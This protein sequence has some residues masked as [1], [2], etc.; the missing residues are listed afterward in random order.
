M[1]N[2]LQLFPQYW[3]CPDRPLPLL[4]IGLGSAL[5]ALRLHS[6]LLKVLHRSAY[7]P[8][9]L[10]V[11][12]LAIFFSPTRSSAL[13]PEA[14]ETGSLWASSPDVAL[15]LFP[16]YWPYPERP[17]P[18]LLIG[19]GSALEALRLHSLLLKVLHR[20]AYCPSALPVPPLAIFFSPTRSSALVPEAKETGS[21][22]ASSPDVA[23][24][25]FPHYWPYPERPLPL[26]L[27]GLGSALEAL[28][29]HSLLLKVLHR[30]AYC[31]SA[32]PVPPLAIF[33]SPTRS[34]ALVP[35]AKETGSLWASSPDVA[36]QLF[37]HYWPYPE[38]PLPL[39]LTGL[40]SALEALRLHSLLLKVL[41][42]SAYCPSALPVPHLAIF[43]SPTRSSALV[44]EAKE[45]DSLWASSPDVA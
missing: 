40:G 24:Q 34:S 13:V 19:L 28:R 15:Q 5:E 6:L 8:S 20:S 37:P 11:P 3:P 27:I 39:L 36:L 38:R 10:P 16:H 35:E 29:L 7:C 4:L 41:H 25:L 44:P 26:L 18:L 31:P 33:F 17:L 9:A 22:W 14:K 45:T 42:R 43:F 21:L 32:L 30:S 23:L 12:H 2:S 1:S